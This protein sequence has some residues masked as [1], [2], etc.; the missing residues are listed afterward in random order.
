MDNSKNDT[1]WYNIDMVSIQY[2]YSNATVSVP[3]KWYR[4]LMVLL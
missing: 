2:L 4:I 1:V 3:M